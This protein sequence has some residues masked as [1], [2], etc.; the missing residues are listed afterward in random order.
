MVADFLSFVPNLTYSVMMLS[1]LRS[2]LMLL[3]TFY[4]V[5]I[6]LHEYLEANFYVCLIFMSCCKFMFA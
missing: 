4:T 1:M 6:E 5:D 3:Y 2:R